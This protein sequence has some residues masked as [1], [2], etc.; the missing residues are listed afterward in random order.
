MVMHMVLLKAGE[1][2]LLRIR[3]STGA[4]VL[5]QIWEVS[6]LTV[7]TT[8]ICIARLNHIHECNVRPPGTQRVMRVV[9]RTTCHI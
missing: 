3:F 5:C 1:D 9:A 6:R 4:F 8:I 2:M 7:A